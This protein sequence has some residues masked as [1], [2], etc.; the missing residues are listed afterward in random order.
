MGL[1]KSSDSDMPVIGDLGGD[2]G[3]ESR[4]AD[5]AFSVEEPLV[6][7]RFPLLHFTDDLVQLRFLQGLVPI[8]LFTVS[9]ISLNGFPVTC[10]PEGVKRKG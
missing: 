7:S 2:I 6:G 3:D 4:I 9:S 1:S 10:I 5:S 8:D